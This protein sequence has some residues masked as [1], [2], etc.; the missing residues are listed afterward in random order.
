MPFVAGRVLVSANSPIAFL[1]LVGPGH[2]KRA[3]VRFHI[4]NGG[5]FFFLGGPRVSTNVVISGTFLLVEL[6]V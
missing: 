5:L 1:G 4:G 2:T 3:P 6:I